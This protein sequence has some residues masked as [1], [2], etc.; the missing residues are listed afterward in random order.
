ML[1]IL[2]IDFGLFL[3]LAGVGNA[4]KNMVYKSVGVPAFH[5]FHLEILWLD[6][7]VSICYFEELDVFTDY[8]FCSLLS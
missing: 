5:S 7:S 6:Y 3:P 1:S 2:S 4:A 8:T